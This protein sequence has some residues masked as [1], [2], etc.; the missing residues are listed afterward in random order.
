MT[1]PLPTGQF[2]EAAYR[3]FY[4]DLDTVITGVTSAPGVTPRTFATALEH[5][6]AIGQFLATKKEAL[7][8]GTDGDDTVTG[9]GADIDLYG[10]DIKSTFTSGSGPNSTT[11]PAIF[12]PVSRGVGEKDILVGRNDEALEDGFFLSVPNGNYSRTGATSG[13]TFGKASRLYVGQGDND[14]ARM[15][16]FNAGFDYVSLSGAAQDYIYR[17]KADALAPDGYSLNII[18]K[19]ENDLVGVLEGINDVQPR[20]FLPDGTF[21]LSARIPARGFNDDAYNLGKFGTITPT[22]EGG[23]KDFVKKGTKDQSI[24]V[25]SGAAKDSINL[26]STNKTTGDDTVIAYGKKTLISGVE[27]SV[28]DGAVQAGTGASQKD[29]LVGSL[30]GVDRFLLGFSS[31]PAIFGKPGSRRAT[32]TSAQSFYLGNGSNDFATIQNYE[33]RDRI[34]LAGKSKDYAFKSIDGNIEIS[35]G[36]DLIAKVEGAKSLVSAV[37]FGNGSMSEVSFSTFDEERLKTVSGKSSGSK[38]SDLLQKVISGK[39]SGSKTSDLQQQVRAIFASPTSGGELTKNVNNQG[40]SVPANLGSGDNLNLI[41]DIFA[42]PAFANIFST[43]LE[44][45]LEKVFSQQF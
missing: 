40:L 23:L 17:Y 14:F 4:N 5:Y 38:I 33:S 9:F 2:N 42:N 22:I 6:I 7:F 28:K 45:S 25:F 32:S 36:G 8:T 26:N 29:T 20:A 19:K 15:Q 43:A 1:T 18:T 3:A 34:L 16:N 13:M 12:T 41:N 10:V 37:K 39:S 11:T 27:L 30:D 24:G 35:K 44:Q 31:D 21:R